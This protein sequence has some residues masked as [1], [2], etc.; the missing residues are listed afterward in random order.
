MYVYMEDASQY[1]H[2]AK[3]AAPARKAFAKNFYSYSLTRSLVQ[4][5][6]YN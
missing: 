3:E 2:L 1:F 5:K 4:R 6:N